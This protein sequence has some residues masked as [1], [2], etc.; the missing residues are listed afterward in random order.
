MLI[1]FYCNDIGQ[2]YDLMDAIQSIQE[3]REACFIM[4]KLRIACFMVNLALIVV[5]VFIESI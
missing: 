3:K 1:V 2:H 4:L 5:E